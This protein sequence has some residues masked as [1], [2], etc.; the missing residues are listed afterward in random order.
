ML[1]LD[2]STDKTFKQ[3]AN[4]GFSQK[5]FGNS[6]PGVYG[7][8]NI[9]TDSPLQFVMQ[10][11]CE[12]TLILRKKEFVEEIR[13][14]LEGP[15]CHRRTSFNIIDSHGAFSPYLGSW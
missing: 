1:G 7:D 3:T 11:E 8:S 12:L 5:N 10:I 15:D 2:D 9:Q 14:L 4:F 6:L 13:V